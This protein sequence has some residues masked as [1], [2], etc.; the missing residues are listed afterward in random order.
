[1]ADWMNLM[2]I[3]V[4]EAEAADARAQ[5]EVATESATSPRLPMIEVPINDGR[6][7]SNEYAQL[8]WYVAHDLNERDKAFLQVLLERQQVDARAQRLSE[9]G[10]QAE[11]AEHKAYERSIKENQSLQLQSSADQRSSSQQIGSCSSHSDTKGGKLLSRLFTE[12][13]HDLTE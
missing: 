11:A 12:K 10:G 7:T 6:W 9:W 3:A 2:A 5:D 4:D 1:M 8:L 13:Q